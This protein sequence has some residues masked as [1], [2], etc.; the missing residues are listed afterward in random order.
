[1]LV[2][3]DGLNYLGLVGQI[4]NLYI[5]RYIRKTDENKEQK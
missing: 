5:I 3:I 2:F 4:C 1:M